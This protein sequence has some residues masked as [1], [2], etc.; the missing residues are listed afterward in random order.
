MRR[1][2]EDIQAG[3]FVKEFIADNRAKQ[4]GDEG[5]P[6]ASSRTPAEETGEKLR[7]DAVDRRQQ[8][9]DKERTSRRA[10]LS[11][12][13]SQAGGEAFARRETLHQWRTGPCAF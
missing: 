4:S 3:R 2:L 8:V 10:R 13:R 11:R 9:V 12:A 5:R 1:V 6:Q 7:A